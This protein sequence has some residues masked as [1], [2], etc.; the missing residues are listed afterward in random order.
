[1]TPPHR[2]WSPFFVLPDGKR[3]PTPRSA[4]TP[5]G[6]GDR[7]RAAAFAEI[8]AREAFSWAGSRYPDAPPRLRAVWADLAAAEDRHLGWLLRRMEELDVDPAGRPVSAALWRSLTSCDDAET[9]C[10]WMADAE[11]RGRQAGETIGAALADVDPTTARLFATIAREEVAHI[12]V[13]SRF[14]GPDPRA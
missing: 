14:F 2:D 3:A 13:A 4:S 8:Q 11:E 1:M 6:I 5:V 7:L 12:A 10:R 9:F